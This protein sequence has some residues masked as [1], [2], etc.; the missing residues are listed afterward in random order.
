MTGETDRSRVVEAV[1]DF[2]ERKLRNGDLERAFTAVVALV[3]FV[4]TT[5]LPPTNPMLER[6]D[7][8]LNLLF[9]LDDAAE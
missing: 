2:G 7:G 8:L 9:D 5:L 1:D 4:V 3:A 6:E